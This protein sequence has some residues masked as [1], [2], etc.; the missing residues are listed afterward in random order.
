MLKR[1]YFF[2]FLGAFL[3]YAIVLVV[4]LSFLKVHPHSAW[5]IPMTL[6]PVIPIG[7]MMSSGHPWSPPYG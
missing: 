2:E 1:H 7:F 4:S 6:A 5:Q 3:A